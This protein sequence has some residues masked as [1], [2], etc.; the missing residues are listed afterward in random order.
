M[1]VIGV[2][3]RVNLEESYNFGVI[4]RTVAILAEVYASN[5]T[6]RFGMIDCEFEIQLKETVIQNN[7]PGLIMIKNGTIYRQERLK[8]S[9]SQMFDFIENGYQNHKINYRAVGRYTFVGLQVT[10]VLRELRLNQQLF[11]HWLNKKQLDW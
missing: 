7:E 4:G 6:M 3:K 1:W 11:V 8:D 5:Q 2:T 10:K 9:H